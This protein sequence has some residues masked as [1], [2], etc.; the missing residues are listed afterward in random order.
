MIIILRPNLA[1]SA[2]DSS[3]RNGAILSGCRCGLVV[4]EFIER[5]LNARNHRFVM[6]LRRYFRWHGLGGVGGVG[7]ALLAIVA[8]DLCFSIITWCPPGQFICWKH[9]LFAASI[10]ECSPD[11]FSVT[12]S[13]CLHSW[14]SGRPEDRG[15]RKHLAAFQR[16]PC[17]RRWGGQK[18]A[19]SKAAAAA[20]RNVSDRSG[21]G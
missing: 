18:G 8:R 14:F 7:P 16:T 10:S 5:L 17:W 21:R 3:L 13:V 12:S 19:D 9:K 15:R 4:A 11:L 1:G 20:E 2:Q 6:L